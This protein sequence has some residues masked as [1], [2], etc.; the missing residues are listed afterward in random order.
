MTK[1]KLLRPITLWKH[2]EI[3]IS[4]VLLFCLSLVLD[5]A[6]EILVTYGVVLI[7]EFAHFFT[8]RYLGV[9]TDKFEIL[10]FG[11]TMKLK[12]STLNSP[13]DEFKIALAGP[14]SN[15]AMAVV[16]LIV[17]RKTGSNNDFLLYIVAVNCGIFVMNIFP[18]LPL[19]GGRMLKCF[20]T[21][22]YGYIK[23]YNLTMLV[24]KITAVVLSFLGL[25]VVWITKFNFSVLL[26]GAFL[27]ANTL[28][29]QRGKSMILMREILYSR[30]K[31]AEI[32]A[33]NSGL[34]TIMADSPARKALKILTYNKYY[35]IN[36]VDEDMNIIGTVTETKLIEK[37]IDKGI[38]I[39]AKALL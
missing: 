16:F 28:S 34:I 33:K 30:Q 22:E 6:E 17:Y 1:Q 10:P 4:A 21:K 13:D 9:E 36:V 2:L 24:T 26:I 27:I 32:G 8:A 3:H 18:A 38:R 31:L 19:D 15:V 5:F 11:V 23:A 25:F 20:L 37:L 12:N 39:D 14:L 29:E 35:N 7:H